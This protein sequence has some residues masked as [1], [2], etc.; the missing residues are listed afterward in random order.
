MATFPDVA[1]KDFESGLAKV[2][3]GAD[4]GSSKTALAHVLYDAAGNPVLTAAQVTSLL[5]YVDGLETLITSSNTKL[6][7]VITSL[8]T[9][10]GRVDGLE[11]FVDGLETLIGSTNTKLDTAITSLQVIDDMVLAAGSATIGKLAANSGVDI[12]DVDVKTING[13]APAYGAGNVGAT[14]PR[15]A[16]ADDSAGILTAGTA[17]SASSEV[18]TVQGI[19]SMTPVRTDVNSVPTK[20]VTVSM[21]TPAGAMAAGDVIAATQIVAACTSGNDIPGLLQSA[22]LIDTDDVGANIKA[23]F[24]SANTSLGA[25]DAAPDI[26]DTEA[27]TQLGVV[28]FAA[29]DYEDLGA[30][31]SN[32]K[33]NIGLGVI[34]ASGT[35][36][37]YMALYSP[38]GGTW[39]SQVITVRLGFI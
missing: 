35:D 31:K 19:A 16:I 11:G 39:A 38:T 24:F 36:D 33:T 15:V 3:K 4:L 26:D 32:T 18:L 14:V 13:V 37:I 9:I 12:G 1:V 10:D 20:Y 29:A 6:D 25:E 5:G 17:G 34:P 22:V 7:T 2:V 30:S 8:S 27:L 21:S 23:V 28:N